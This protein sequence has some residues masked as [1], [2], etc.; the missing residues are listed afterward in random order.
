[1][2]KSEQLIAQLDLDPHPEGGFFKETYRANGEIDQTSLGEGF[3]SNRKYCT[4]IYFLLTANN[5]SS[6]HRIKQDEMWHFY[7]GSPLLLHIIS[8]DGQYTHQ[9]IGRDVLKGEVPQYVVPAGHWFAAEVVGNGEYCLV[10]CTV[11]PGFSFEDFELAQRKQLMS[12][13]P[14]FKDMITRLTRK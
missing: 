7:D 1:M 11:S 10:G 5:F 3:S 4:G 2:T 9:T 12:R 13:F 6:F 8:E 14:A